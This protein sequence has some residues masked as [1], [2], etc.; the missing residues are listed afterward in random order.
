MA[1]YQTLSGYVIS[2]KQLGRKLG[3]PT[4]NVHVYDI[5]SV[6]IGVWFVRIGIDGV[7]Y[8]GV[9]NIGFRPTVTKDRNPLLEVFIFDFSKDI[10][11]EVIVVEFLK[12]IR[13]EQ[14]FES[15]EQLKKSVESDIDFARN[16]LKHNNEYESR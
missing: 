7:S 11:G 2:G 8:Y 4:A 13:E 5:G 12:Y 15:V 14:K 16:E 9:A 1:N 6:Q 10:Y 3:F